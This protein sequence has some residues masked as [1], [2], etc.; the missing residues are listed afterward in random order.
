MAITRRTLRLEQQLERA[1]DKVLDAQTRD[2]V[3][4]WAIA[5]DEVVPDLR[6]TLAEL[7][8]ADTEITR[9]QMRRAAR[10]R[11]ALTLITEQLEALAEEAGIRITGDVQAVVDAA[12]GAQA[13]IIDSQLPPGADALVD[14]NAWSRVD[15]R[16]V[17]AIVERTTE[18][19][20]SRTRLLSDDA[21]DAVRRELIRGVVVGA[22]PK[23][24]ARRIL[25][26]TEG[27]FNGGLTRA[28]TIAR[29][30]T[31]DAHRR[32]GAIAHEQHDDVLL[33]W[34]WL[35]HLTPR[36]CRSCWAMHGRLF[37]LSD[38]G[39]LDHQQGRCSRCPKV[40]PWSDLGFD[41][42][43]PD[44]LTPDADAD[45]AALTADQQREIL[46]RDGYDAWVAGDFPREE[47]AKRR[48][49]DGW[50]DSYVPAKPGEPN[51]AGDGVQPPSGPPAPPA[52]D[53]DDDLPPIGPVLGNVLQQA[54]V[55][56]GTPL[57][58]R[59]DE[60]GLPMLPETDNANFEHVYVADR[61]DRAT[62]LL[63][64]DARSNRLVRS[65]AYAIAND[66]EHDLDTD[67]IVDSF[68]ATLHNTPGTG[69]TAEAY[70]RDDL[71]ADIIA[72][73]HWLL[74]Q[75]TED[76]GT[77]YRGLRITTVDALDDDMAE[78]AVAAITTAGWWYVSSSPDVEI[79][80]M[81]ADHSYGVSVVMEIV[82]AHGV[83]L[84]SMGRMATS[85]EAL[86]TGEIEILDWRQS[87]VTVYVKARWVR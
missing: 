73:A 40:K 71:V 39:P 54:Y 43:E 81:Y 3:R 29:T 4:A 19:I 57:P 49:A 9:T 55:K 24:T 62:A 6:D 34:E 46:G 26:R 59:R 2:L 30:E 64:Y 69:V 58:R 23:A 21:Q 15:A 33:G 83:R 66:Q 10:L 72:A 12:G 18:R 52:A 50:R 76:L 8:V 53:G 86:L 28:M 79:S 74:E 1:L 47:W 82:D 14:L 85:P 56:D 32:A 48:E 45:F 68:L 75:P 63:Q 80:T 37:P 35:A 13:S 17:A 70:T 42:D 77:T 22:N 27:A 41:V 11:K 36:T 44:D 31:V 25:A 65:T 20:T 61:G 87:G 5:W 67:R 7:L 84:R 60:R 16:Q 51:A 38:P 78:R